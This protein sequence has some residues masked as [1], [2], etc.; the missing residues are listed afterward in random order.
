MKPSMI[1]IGVTNDE[2]E[3]PVKIY[4]SYQE[5]S[6]DLKISVKRCYDLINKKQEHKK[7]NLKFYKYKSWGDI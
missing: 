4:T 1:I 6:D 3:L 5:M 2:Y 7:T